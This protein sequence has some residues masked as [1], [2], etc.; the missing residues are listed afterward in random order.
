[1]IINIIIL[2]ALLVAIHFI[3]LAIGIILQFR[4]NTPYVDELID[5]KES[6]LKTVSVN[7]LLERIGQDFLE[8]EKVK[9]EKTFFVRCLVARVG[10][11]QSSDINDYKDF[12]EESVQET[13]NINTFEVL[14]SVDWYSLGIRG[15]NHTRFLVERTDNEYSN[16]ITEK[17][18]E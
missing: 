15:G 10:R 4:K 1:M 3:F 12:R 5:E 7:K 16:I 13:E 6:E 8:E 18:F 17:K 11:I 2:A 9:N 14:I